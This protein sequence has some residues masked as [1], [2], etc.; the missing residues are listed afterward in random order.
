MLIVGRNCRELAHCSVRG[1]SGLLTKDET[2]LLIRKGSQTGLMRCLA[3]K[4]CLLSERMRRKCDG[5]NSYGRAKGNKIWA[6]RDFS[7]LPL[8]QTCPI[9]PGMKAKA[10]FSG[11]HGPAWLNLTT[12][13]MLGNGHLFFVHFSLRCRSEQILLDPGIQNE[14]CTPDISE[15]VNSIEIDHVAFNFKYTNSHPRCLLFESVNA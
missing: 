2:G 14:S 11:V 6:R 4:G 3:L 15:S 1:K 12:P 10:A 9:A 7:P 13:H 5:L 8:L